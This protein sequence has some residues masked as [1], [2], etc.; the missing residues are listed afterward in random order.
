MKETSFRQSQS[1]GILI[2]LTCGI[3]WGI[4]GILGQYVFGTGQLNAIELTIIRMFVSG[5][6]LLLSA[7]LRRD[8]RALAIWRSPRHLLSLLFFSAI[9]IM[10]L[11]FTYLASI[12]ES[13]A[14]TGTVIQFTY[15]VM[16]LLYAAVVSR[17]PPKTYETLA[18]LCAFVGI[19]LIATHGRFDSLAVSTMA[20]VWG[21]LSALCFCVY[22]LYPQRLYD[23]YG[24][25]TVIGW[26]S[27][28][29]AILLMLLTQTFHLP[30]MDA[31][32]ALASVGV[33]IIGTLIPFTLYGIG[34]GILGTIKASLFVTVEP[35]SSALLTWLIFGTVFTLPDIMGFLLILGAIEVVAVMTFRDSRSKT[36]QH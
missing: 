5:I 22:C 17:K 19:F 29:S 14:A 3:L 33:A 6:V 2:V 21:L 11:Q 9:G 18:V 31:K 28:F 12:E 20:L 32:V 16:L 30:A 8:R 13:N 27:L 36:A 15:I 4:S 1:F 24:L 10:G 7:L 26:G 23:E 34:I 35:I 25:P